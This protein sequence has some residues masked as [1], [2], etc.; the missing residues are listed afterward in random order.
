VHNHVSEEKKHLNRSGQ[1]LVALDI[2]YI[3]IRVNFSD[4]RLRDFAVDKDKFQTFP[5]SSL[6]IKNIKPRKMY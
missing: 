5:L 2:N 1:N 3:I 4:D 6:R